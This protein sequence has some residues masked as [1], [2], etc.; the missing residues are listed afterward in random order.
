M[1]ER[2]KDIID[3]LMSAVFLVTASRSKYTRHVQVA[4][5]SM[6]SVELISPV[7]RFSKGHSTQLRLGITLLDGKNIL[8]AS[9]A[10]PL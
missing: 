8:R 6:R 7:E 4:T 3:N 1:D 9:N 10:D 2:P 5:F